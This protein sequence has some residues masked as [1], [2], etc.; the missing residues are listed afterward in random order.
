MSQWAKGPRRSHYGLI[1]QN[2]RTSA[3]GEKDLPQNKN[4]RWFLHIWGNKWRKMRGSLQKKQTASMSCRSVLF[5]YAHI[6]V[7]LSSAL[8]ISLSVIFWSHLQANWTVNHQDCSFF[9]FQ[10][11]CFFVVVYSISFLIV[12]CNRRWHK[13]DVT[14]ENWWALTSLC[15]ITPSEEVSLLGQIIV[16]VC[17][18]SL[19]SSYGFSSL[20]VARSV[21]EHV[22]ESVGL[23]Q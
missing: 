23:C 17:G 2:K 8:G 9:S 7:F 19:W 10:N 16:W 20:V 12:N 13:F 21:S 22:F 15:Q 1:T 3:G 5:W 18:V 11:I 14:G 4:E 6:S